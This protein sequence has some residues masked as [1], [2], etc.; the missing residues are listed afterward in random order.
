MSVSGLSF[1]VFWGTIFACLAAGLPGQAASVLLNTDQGEVGTVD[2]FSGEFVPMFAGSSFNDIALS[3]Q[4]IAVG[5]TADNQL[6]RVQN[7]AAEFVGSLGLSASVIVTGLS[8][9]PQNRLYA[10]GFEAQTQEGRV[11]QVDASTGLA[12][13]LVSSL[14]AGRYQ[15]LVFDAD[16]NQFFAV[17]QATGS[18]DSVLWA[19]ALN[20][21]AADI[22]SIGFA[23]VTGL[24]IS[25]GALYGYTQQGQ[26]LQI[27]PFTGAGVFDLAVN[28]PVGSNR[29]F[30]GAASAPIPFTTVPQ[31]SPVP[32]PS[33]LLA[34]MAAGGLGILMRRRQHS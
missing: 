1:S 17:R 34:A 21:T 32:E 5:V 7:G 28:S 19:L 31:P 23:A 20:G 33:F 3:Q 24:A 29:Q 26:Q 12:T 6:Y 13:L 14:P 27:N 10:L 4:R 22:G 25:N 16:R 18:A 2:P 15:D 9:D 8:F 11:Y 30:L